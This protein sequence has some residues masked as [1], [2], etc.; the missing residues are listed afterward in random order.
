MANARAGMV[1]MPMGFVNRI[2]EPSFYFG[3]NRPEVERR[4]IPSTWREMGVG[5]FGAI[6]PELT[7]T[8][9]V[10]NGLDATGFSS[11]GIREGRGSGSN[12]KAE[13]FAFVA[14]VDYGLTY[15]PALL[16]AVRPMLE[17]QDKIRL[18]RGPKCRCLYATL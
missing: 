13:N 2:H 15:Y 7:Y 4:I 16:S 6:S 12:A 1:L 3:N 5:L 14:R 10:V 18:L 9:Y 11:D 8:A 17:T